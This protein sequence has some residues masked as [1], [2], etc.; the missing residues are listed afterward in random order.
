MKVKPIVKI[1]GNSKIHLIQKWLSKEKIK[2]KKEQ[3]GQIKANSQ[4]VDLNPTL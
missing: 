1:A 2:R 4:M 3:M